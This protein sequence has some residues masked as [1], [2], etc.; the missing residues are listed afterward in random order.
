MRK[1]RALRGTSGSEDEL[2]PSALARAEHSRLQ[3]WAA[4]G[5]S[6]DRLVTLLKRVLPISAGVLGAFLLAAPFTH[7][8][9][10]S[11]VLDKNKVDVASERLKVTEALYR[12]EDGEGRPFSLRAGSALQKTSRDPIVQLNELEARLQ[13]EGGGAVVTARQGNYNIENETVAVNG[14]IQFQSANGYR[15]TTRD[16]D[17]RLQE[18]DL[19]SRGDVEGRMPTGTF[20]A[21]HL[22][23][24]LE[25]RTVTLEGNAR[26]RMEQV[27]R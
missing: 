8:T 23:A 4:P 9:E 7:Q 22:K 14:P 11:F 20:R 2:A 27:G 3:R 25:G 6:H 5:G 21:D 10:V 16:V 15:L 13:M 1:G 26:L 17:I 18:R 12:G 24:D 19:R